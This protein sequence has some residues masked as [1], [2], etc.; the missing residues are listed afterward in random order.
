MLTIHY[1]VDQEGGLPNANQS[2]IRSHKSDFRQLGAVSSILRES[3]WVYTGFAG[4]RHFGTTQKIPTF[5]RQKRPATPASSRSRDRVDPYS[6]L[7]RF[8]ARQTAPRASQRQFGHQE[9]IFSGQIA[10]LL[11]RA[12]H[13]TPAAWMMLISVPNRVLNPVSNR[14]LSVGHS[15]RAQMGQFS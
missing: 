12:K 4:T 10:Q 6:K 13:F 3:V 9:R 11:A 5:A 2:K 7:R 8:G 15:I 1:W 14:V